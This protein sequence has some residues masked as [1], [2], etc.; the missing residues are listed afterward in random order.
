[1]CVINAVAAGL[2]LIHGVDAVTGSD[3]AAT[4]EVGT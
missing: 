2:A 3:E 1:V 4:I